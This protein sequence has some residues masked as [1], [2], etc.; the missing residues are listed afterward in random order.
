M[1][2]RIILLGLRG[3]GKSTLGPLL[4]SKRSLAFIDLDDHTRAHLQSP[5]IAQAWKLHGETAFRLAEVHCLKAALAKPATVISLGGGT[6]T[7]PNAANLLE[8]AKA[9]GSHC[10][11]YLR[12]TPATLAQRLQASG[13]GDRPSLTGSDP[14]AEIAQVFA[15]RDPLYQSLANTTLNLDTLTPCESIEALEKITKA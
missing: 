10:L 4:A 5:T 11:I 2:N 15:A 3:S 8:S 14:I 7:A 13:I 12:A 6:P 1:I 9:A